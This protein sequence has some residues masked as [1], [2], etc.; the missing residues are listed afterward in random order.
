LL[1][2]TLPSVAVVVPTRSRPEKLGHCLESLAAARR[3]LQFQTYV[4]DSSPDEAD[5]AAVR[6]ACERHEWVHLS[7]HDGC[8]IAAAR[9][10]CARVAHE[11]LLVSVDD[12]L[13]LEPQAVE[14]LVERYLEGSGPR[15]VSGSVSWDGTWSEPMKMRPI[16]YSRVPRDGEQPDFVLGALFLYPRSLAVACP[17]NERCDRRVDI[18]MGAVWRAHSVRI[19]FEPQARALH[20]DLP[21]NFDPARIDEA[22]R[23][24]RWHAYVL[25]FDALIANPSLL[26]AVSYEV[27][28]FMASG[29]QYLR[30]PRWAIGFVYNWI[31]GHVRLLADLRYLRKMVKK[32]SL[33]G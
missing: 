1:N 18:L 27:L 23:N 21:A 2:K 20:D 22:V 16:G 33:V 12:D 6:E 29:K 9:N 7:R 10:A 19:L 32:D 13:E 14:R 11:D 8:N 31:V 3:S 24:E 25:L 5:H 4:C 17:W 26:N 30:R 15:V 28:G